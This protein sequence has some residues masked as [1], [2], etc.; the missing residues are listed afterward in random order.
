MEELQMGNLKFQTYDL[1]VHTIA[2][3]LW[4]EYYT[5]VDGVVFLLDAADRARFPE[6]KAELDDLLGGDDLKDVPFLVLGNKIDV[7][8]AA[9]EEE[10]RQALGLFTTWGKTT[11]GSKAAAS[12]R[13]LRPVEVFMC[14][15]VRRQGYKDGFQWLAQFI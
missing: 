3:R 14:S 2:R 15:I 12:E 13:G 9:S 11:G 5:D 6:S 4:R 1:G 8:G 10:V 7:A